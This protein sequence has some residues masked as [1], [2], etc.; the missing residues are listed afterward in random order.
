M[1]TPIWQ[2]IQTSLSREITDGRFLAGD[3]LPTEAALSQR[4]GVNRHTVRRALA[5]MQSAGMV[6][7]RRG[8]GV[9]V[10]GA[11]LTYR[12][13]PRTR[14]SQNLRESGHIGDR[15]IIRL[16]TLPATKTDAEHLD[17]GKGDLIHIL[18]AIGTIDGAPAFFGHGMFPAARLTAFPDAMRAT[19]SIT[20]ALMA[21]GVEN[22]R[23][24]WTR[25]SAER[26][27][28]TVAR[29]LRIPE[30]APVL[31]TKALNREEDGSPV[32]YARTMF[33]A[34]R[35]ELLIEGA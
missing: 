17:I 8:A 6:H 28:G 1:T 32:E 14:F 30:G 2:Q 7:A 15:E 29:H 4:F 35:V 16:E 20:A 11:P 22:Y 25:L 9:F 33:C 24:D 27:N 21:S 13:G 34:D 19:H 3:K 23:R 12:V 26:A 10:T 31:T 5:E 18:E